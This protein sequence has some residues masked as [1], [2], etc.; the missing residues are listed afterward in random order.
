MRA[1]DLLCLYEIT[2]KESKGPWLA[3]FAGHDEQRLHLEALV[4]RPQ[5]LDVVVLLHVHNFLRGRHGVDRH[6]VVAAILSTTSRPW[7]LLSSRSSARLP[8]AIGTIES[9]ASG[10]PQRTR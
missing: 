3:H 2:C 1:G 9:I 7:I 6:V 5:P 10:S 8:Y 4:V